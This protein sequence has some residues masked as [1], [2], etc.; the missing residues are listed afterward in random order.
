[1]KTFTQSLSLN[2]TPFSVPSGRRKT[3][4][5]RHQHGPRASSTPAKRLQ[6]GL[7]RQRRRNWCQLHPGELPDEGGTCQNKE[8]LRQLRERRGKLL[9]DQILNAARWCPGVEFEVSWPNHRRPRGR[10]TASQVF[11]LWHRGFQTDS[12]LECSQCVHTGFTITT[13]QWQNVP[14]LDQFINLG[15]KDQLNCNP[16]HER[17]CSNS[18]KMYIELKLLNF[19][20]CHAV[21]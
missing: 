12:I 10:Y 7:G 8:R 14:Y 18:L 4:R 1:M 17:K 3:R 21:L 11:F 15:E 2:L 13:K 16:T 5:R 19:L 9:W 20:T 6:L